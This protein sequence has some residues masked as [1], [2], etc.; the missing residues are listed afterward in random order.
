MKCQLSE[1]T[2]LWFEFSFDF[3]SRPCLLIRRNAGRVQSHKQLRL[4][5]VYE[6]SEVIL[7]EAKVVGFYRLQREVKMCEVVDEASGP[8]SYFFRCSIFDHFAQIPT[9]LTLI[10]NPVWVRFIR[11]WGD[12]NR[13]NAWVLLFSSTR[14]FAKGSKFSK[15]Q[16]QQN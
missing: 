1:S 7:D 5:S 6:L 13:S 3:E 16:Y 11:H 14:P 4:P 12:Q 9:E 8:V 2:T 15:T 10:E